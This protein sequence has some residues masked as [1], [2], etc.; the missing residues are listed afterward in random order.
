MS[1]AESLVHPWIKVRGLL[2]FPDGPRGAW[3]G[4]DRQASKQGDA[5]GGVRWVLLQPWGSGQPLLVASLFPEGPGWGDGMEPGAKPKTG[6]RLQR[7]QAG[8]W[9]VENCPQAI[10]YGMSP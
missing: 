4:G 10:E 2:A 8:A 5:H 6:G 9:Q 3:G 7:Q 1:A